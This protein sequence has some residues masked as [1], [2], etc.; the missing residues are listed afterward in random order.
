MKA[1]ALRIAFFIASVLIAL[2][3]SAVAYSETAMA[4]LEVLT[5]KP[6]YSRGELVTVHAVYR[7]ADVGVENSNV[8][9]QVNYPNDTLYLAWADDTGADG[10]ATLVFLV[11]RDAPPGNYSVYATAYKVG[12]GN[13][14]ANTMFVVLE[15]IR[16]V[17]PP[18]VNAGPDQT[19]NEDTRVT[20]DGSRS[21]DNIGITSYTWTF[22]DVTP[23]TLT[24]INPT[25]NFTNPSVYVVVLNVTDAAGN[26]ATD[27]VTITVLDVTKP[28]ADAG[29][30]QTVDVNTEVSLDAGGSS[31]NVG[32]TSYEWDFGDGARGTGKTT[33]HAYATP[34]V[35]TV[36]LNV[37][38][39]AGNS[40]TDTATITVRA[41]PVLFPWWT[42]GV[43]LVAA[44]IL[45]AAVY[46]VKFRKPGH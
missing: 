2:S 23:Q 34:G 8:L 25:Y 5:D 35:Y 29:G 46:L 19:V 15:S 32:I 20:F 44:I 10:I 24:G 27:N 40:A 6:V 17:T 4:F 38:D 41:A 42:A 18:L 30:D 16:D 26:Y 22:T 28:V 45:T 37:T 21:W 7:V 3:A 33:K 12:L 39:A 13:T 43:V 14:T 1:Y 36:T 11:Y 9:F 31:D